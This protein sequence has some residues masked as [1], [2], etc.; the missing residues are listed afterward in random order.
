MET[1]KQLQE[2][3]TNKTE[4]DTSKLNQPVPESAYKCCILDQEGNIKQ[5]MVFS[6]QGN[7]IDFKD[8]YFSEEERSLYETLQP[9]I[10]SS[11]QLIHLDD[12]ICTIKKKIL[13]RYYLKI[14][15][16]LLLLM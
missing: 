3:Q 4:M 11:S 7:S 9:D 15:M 6:G 5:I 16:F 8:N 1:Q 12:S 14:L 2:T 10:I 13:N